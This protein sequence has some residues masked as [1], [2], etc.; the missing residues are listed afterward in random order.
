[1]TGI[2]PKGNAVSVKMTTHLWHSSRMD[3][4]LIPRFP[5]YVF[6]MQRLHARTT[7]T[8]AHSSSRSETVNLHLTVKC[9]TQNIPCV[10]QK[11]FAGAVYCLTFSG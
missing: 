8:I 7:L 6:N 10:A 4:D 3:G 2:C 5:I 11:V 1:V 9:W